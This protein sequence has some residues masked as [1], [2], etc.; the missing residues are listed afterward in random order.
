[1]RVA[2][3]RFDVAVVHCLLHQLEVAAA[4]QKLCAEVVPEIMEAEVSQTSVGA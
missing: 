1:V 4:A 3:R 2:E